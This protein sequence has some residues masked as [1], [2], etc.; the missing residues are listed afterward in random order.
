M[1]VLILSFGDSIS[2]SVKRYLDAGS[3]GLPIMFHAGKSNREM[4]VIPLE[5]LRKEVAD[6]WWDQSS[7]GRLVLQQH[8]IKDRNTGHHLAEWSDKIELD[9]AATH[10]LY[11]YSIVVPL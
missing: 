4:S 5:C 7:N 10:R 2:Q 9:T 8:A 3:G 6:N 11:R 1:R